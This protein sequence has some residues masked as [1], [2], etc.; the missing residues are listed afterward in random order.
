MSKLPPVEKLPLALRKNVRDAWDAKKE[1]LEGKISE[2]LGT[3]WTIDVNPN[4][5]YAYANDGY[6]K[7]SLGA[8]IYAYFDGARGRLEEFENKYGEDG[9][10][11][12]NTICHTHVLTM[13]VDDQKRFTYCGS[14]VQDGQ[15]RLL[16]AP[17]RLGSNI[18]QCLDRD[19]L[20]KALNDAPVPEDASLSFVVRTS[21]RQDYDPKIQEIQA[22]VAEIL[23]KP[24]IKL[25]ADWDGIYAKLK[26]ESLVK[27]TDLRKDWEYSMG[28]L[29]RCYFDGLVSQLQWQKF[30]DDELLQEGFHD[31]ADKGEFVLRV[32]D[33][34]SGSD[35]YNECVIENGVVYLQTVPKNW[36]SNVDNAA[37]K[38]VDML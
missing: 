25:T 23:N 28:N 3:P 26:A 4:Q 36:G 19:V 1:E 6:A 30:E 14:D 18:S 22:K 21:I 37:K 35:S 31:V 11:E 17:D 5:I 29:A 9:V 24:D 20:L 7:E 2:I 34:L 27:K 12:L 32:V 16:F 8:C 13:D 33:K 15:L 10:K 38:L